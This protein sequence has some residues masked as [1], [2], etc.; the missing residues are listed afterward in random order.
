VKLL[1]D[2]HAI[3]W[4]ALEDPQLSVVARSLLTDPANQL[5]V[6][7]ASYWEIGIKIALGKYPVAT[8][9]A[10]FMER[11]IRVNGYQVVPILPSHA[12]VI[13]TLPFHHRD[14]FDRMLVAQAMVEGYSLVSS[15]EMFDRYGV[16]RFW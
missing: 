11:Q 10:A 12:G 6:S 14:P 15:D 7:P 2:T 16:T 5:F 8:D 3:L 9:L 1:L 4:F 13:A